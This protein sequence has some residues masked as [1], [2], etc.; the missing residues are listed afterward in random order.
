M[1]F[2]VRS[3]LR[4]L[5]VTI[6]V[7][8]LLLAFKA[9][10]LV[11]AATTPEPPAHKSAGAAPAAAA[12]A[13]ATSMP[14]AAPA[15]VLPGT[16]APARTAPADLPSEAERA[17]LL[18]LRHRRAELDTRDATLAA[19]EAVLTATEKRLATRLEE[20]NNLQGRLQA[21]ERARKAREEQNWQGLVKL[22][23]QMKPRDAATIF[24]DLDKSVLLAVL[25][26]M[27]EA[28][29]AA[30]LAA[31]QPDRARLATTE[32]ARLRTRDS[33]PASPG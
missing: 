19:R 1:N 29:A 15:T 10:G 4:L 16:P 6:A 5:P 17:L 32:L 27:K 7:M 12:P 28:K 13:A 20:L 21:M 24:N 30:V 25:D 9:V 14:N 2:K 33:T 23:E 8:L 26:R 18:D 31:M 22:Y 3:Q 11:R